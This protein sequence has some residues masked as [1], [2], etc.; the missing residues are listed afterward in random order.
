[1]SL[2]KINLADHVVSESAAK[3]PSYKIAKVNGVATLVINSEKKAELTTI[4]GHLKKAK[5]AGVSAARNIDAWSK[6]RAK[7]KTLTGDAKSR[8]SAKAA[9]YKA[10]GSAALKEAKL[11]LKES[12][13]YARKHGL[14]GLKMGLTSTSLQGI[15]E[16]APKVLAALR[17]AKLNEFG[18][19]GKRGQFKPKFLASAKFDALGSKTVTKAAKKAPVAKASTKKRKDLVGGGA[20]SPEKKRAIKADRA[21]KL[22]GKPKAS[23]LDDA[24]AGDPSKDKPMLGKTVLDSYSTKKVPG[25]KVTIQAHDH[26]PASKEVKNIVKN[27]IEKGGVS[28]G[29]FV[30][31]ANSIEYKL[32]TA[33]YRMSKDSKTGKWNSYANFGG[34]GGGSNPGAP[35]ASA[36]KALETSIKKLQKFKKVDRMAAQNSWH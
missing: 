31:K 33:S 10:K 5:T 30:V 24:M 9:D 23:S 32:G 17:T 7:V 25:T 12:A 22:L 18:V 36:R 11:H 3:K 6:A 8:A 16:K 4:L 1:M 14:S 21:E 35:Y 34:N 27:L 13:S 15:T 19:T 29:K 26:W 20:Y 28:K 2:I